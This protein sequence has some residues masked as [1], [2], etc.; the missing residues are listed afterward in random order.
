MFDFRLHVFNTV[1][2]KLN[3]SKASEVLF[4]SQS[5]VSKHIQE[6]EFHFKIKLFER[7]GNTI[8]LT[9]AGKTLLK[10]TEKIIEFY[11]KLEFDMNLLINESSGK[12]RI[13]ASTTIA[14]NILPLILAGFK[15]KYKN[16]EISLSV[17]NSER[18]ENALLEK[19]ID[20]GI[21]EGQA[22]KRTLKYDK[23][24]KDELVLVCKQNS[25]LLTCD[26]IHPKELTHL[27]ILLREAG[28]GTLEVILHAL[29][30]FGIKLADLNLEMQL[31]SSESIKLYLLNSQSCAFL[32]LHS[33]FRELKNN[34]LKIIEIENLVIQRDFYF[35][36]TQGQNDSL[37]SEFLNYAK[38]YNF[39]L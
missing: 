28:S 9:N 39:S 7:H 21:I 26:S 16:I 13:G 14:Q 17:N 31:A 18:I 1:A 33:I 8:S 19:N 23:F 15:Q 34:E 11:R 27:P 24:L 36:Q 22:K 10:H 37:A 30:P 38:Q 25:S 2:K 35:I 5:A 3:F 12:L 20:L 4:I 6:L 32:S 29:K